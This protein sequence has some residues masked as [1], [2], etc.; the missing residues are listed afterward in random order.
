MRNVKIKV[1]IGSGAGEYALDA[2]RYAAYSLSAAA[3][4]LIEPAGKGAVQ[5]SF[6]ERP[7]A[8]LAGIEARF[9]Q[10]L[11]DEALREKNFDEN[12]GLREFMILKALSAAEPAKPQQDTGLTADQEK[13]LDALIAQVESEIKEE[14]S[15]GRSGDPLGIA[16]RW[17]DKNV[18]TKNRKKK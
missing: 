16:K 5:V 7:G 6:S 15:S 3:Y 4:V 1:S 8:R 10:A 2:V 9:K 14:T 17:E 18:A 13:E 11:A 12:R